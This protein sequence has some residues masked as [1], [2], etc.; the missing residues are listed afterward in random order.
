MQLKALILCALVCQFAPRANAWDDIDFSSVAEGFVSSLFENGEWSY[1]IVGGIID[2]LFDSN[3]Y[4]SYSSY[5]YEYVYD[6]KTKKKVM[7]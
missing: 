4:S 2:A 3:N 1:D 5:D 6:E 7:I